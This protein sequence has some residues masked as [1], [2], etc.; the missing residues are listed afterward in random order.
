MKGRK[1]DMPACLVFHRIEIKFIYLFSISVIVAG[2]FRC[3]RGR[4]KAVVFW[5]LMFCIFT[6]VYTQIAEG[7]K[8]T[9]AE[10]EKFEDQPEG[11]QVECILPIIAV[12]RSVNVTSKWSV[13]FRVD[14]QI[15][16]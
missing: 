16:N 4:E 10:L 2:L 12:H 15:L 14:H 9:L 3:E 13:L 8:P 7:I 1:S 5:A 11:M 6:A